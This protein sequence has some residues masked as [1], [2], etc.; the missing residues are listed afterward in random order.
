MARRP[1]P[2]AS[3]LLGALL[4][5][6]APSRAGAA[7]GET[8]FLPANSS[9]NGLSAVAAM[10]GSMGQ[11][12]RLTHRL[13]WSTLPP[14]AALILIHPEVELPATEVVA[15]LAGGGRVLLADDFGKG[16]ALLREFDIELVSAPPSSSPR[17]HQGNPNLPVARATRAGS[18]LTQGVREVVTNHP[19]YLRSRL[20]SLLRFGGGDQQLL[21]GA[22]VGKGE[23]LVLADPSVL[24][25]TMM[26]FPGNRTLAR[27]LIRR[28]AVQAGTITLL[29]GQVTF[30][31]AGPSGDDA[32][33]RSTAGTFLREFND[34]LG[35]LNSYAPVDA[36]LRALAVVAAL[37][38]LL[39]LFMFLPLPR[40]DMDGHWSRASASDATGLEEDVVRFS[41][42]WR[43]GGA[44]YPAALL[45]EEVE[46]H[47]GAML[48]APGPLST[49]HPRWI[50]GKVSQRNG[51]E[52]ARLCGKLIAALARVPGLG[53]GL[54]A[55]RPTLGGVSPRELKALYKLSERLFAAMDARPLFSAPRGK[56][57]HEHR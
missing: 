43:G 11:R 33:A 9:W 13:D 56:H 18:P 51:P 1:G 49:V 30:T 45:R 25:N 40:K 7:E 15:F 20:P 14:D 12:L 42:L 44:A 36:G 37:L 55:E 6:T 24:I 19:G 35:V 53:L 41:R 50:V 10:A 34:F 28:L 3:L 52:A 31:G 54:E 27:N 48:D 21:V 57:V 4:L 22:R 23:L 39:G 29:S 17:L 38:G 16:S 8:D 46:E 26:Q 2:C 5:I 32:A 47:L